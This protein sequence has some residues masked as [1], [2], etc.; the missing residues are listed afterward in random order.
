[1]INIYSASYLEKFLQNNGLD[2][3]T[4]S[5]QNTVYYSNI[6]IDEIIN[7]QILMPR[8]I[9][10]IMSSTRFYHFYRFYLWIE[11]FVKPCLASFSFL[12]IYLDN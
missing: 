2:L 10:N 4:E 9:Q 11:R 5:L 7:I 12:D 3:Y 1:M 6:L 8:H